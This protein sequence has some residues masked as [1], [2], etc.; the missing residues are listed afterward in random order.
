M[1]N[2]P[3][4]LTGVLALML[5]RMPPGDL[6]YSGFRSQYGWCEAKKF[7]NLNTVQSCCSGLTFNLL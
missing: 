7:P 6:C 3:A 5:L 2:L 1:S 4:A